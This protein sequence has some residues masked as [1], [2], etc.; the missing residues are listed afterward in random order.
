M[1][2][3][4][5]GAQS[6]PN[7][8]LADLKAKHEAYDPPPPPIFTDPPPKPAPE[9]PRREKPDWREEERLA[10]ERDAAEK[11]AESYPHR[12][13]RSRNELRTSTAPRHS[14]PKREPRYERRP[15]L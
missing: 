12:R 13:R 4:Q 7:A 3:V 8:A 5:R 1:E 10:A 9:P 11:R 2:A 15:W 6:P 14:K